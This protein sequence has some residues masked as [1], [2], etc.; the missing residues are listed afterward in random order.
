MTLTEI[1]K[2]LNSKNG[3]LLLLKDFV[4]IFNDINEIE[5]KLYDVTL[6]IVE[7]RQI[8][9][10]ITGHWL[11]INKAYTLLEEFIEIKEK[12]YIADKE[13]QALDYEEKYSIQS[14]KRKAKTEIFAE[15]KILNNF[16][17][18]LENCD[19]IRFTLQSILKTLIEESLRLSN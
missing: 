1:R 13:K 11:K 6:D 18:Y 7:A 12:K 10:K 8:L 17:I 14:I 5:N 2:K 15:Q 16:K 19:A 9:Q 4:S 3:E